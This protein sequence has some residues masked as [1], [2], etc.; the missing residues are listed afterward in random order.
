MEAFDYHY[1][2]CVAFWWVDT[3]CLEPNGEIR[4]SHQVPNGG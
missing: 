4:W 3:A 2:V 1:K